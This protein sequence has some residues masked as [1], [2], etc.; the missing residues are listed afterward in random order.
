MPKTNLIPIKVKLIMK[1]TGEGIDWPDLNQ[2]SEEIR[3]GLAWSRYIDIRG[4]GW[5]YNKVSNLG[6]GGDYGEA[7]TCVPETFAN[8]A[9]ALFPDKISILTELE[10]EDFYDNYSHIE[11][12]DEEIDFEIIQGI[13]AKQALGLTLTSQQLSAI[14]PNTDTRGIRKNKNRFWVDYKAS[15]GLEI[16]QRAI[17]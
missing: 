8:A 3:E 12:P 4:I 10:F 7:A 13:Q 15:I 6:K 14:D 9:V 1:A 2:I 17:K 11:E 5:H 16:T